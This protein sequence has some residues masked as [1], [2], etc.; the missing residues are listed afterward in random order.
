MTPVAM[1][2]V[3]CREGLS[4]HPDEYAAPADLEVALHVMIDFLERFARS[5]RQPSS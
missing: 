4:H 2:F 3:R 5:S 1:L